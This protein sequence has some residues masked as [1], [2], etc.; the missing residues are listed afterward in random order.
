MFELKENFIDFYFDI[1][2]LNKNFDDFE[3][4]GR[5]YYPLKTNSNEIVLE[6]LLPMISRGENGFLISHLSHYYKLIKMGVKPNRMC[7]INVLA[8]GELIKMLYENGVRYFTFDNLEIL[9]RFSK[10]ADLN[11]TKIA[12]R[13][14]IT[15]VFKDKFSHLGGG[16]DECKKMLSFLKGKCEDYGISFY[17]QREIFSN[18]NS[19]N[20]MLDFIYDNFIGYNMTFLNIGGAKKPEEIDVQRIEDI[21]RQLNIDTIIIEPGRYLV[22]NCVDMETRITK[23]SNIQN[24]KTVIVKNGIY[25]GFVDILLYSKKFEIYFQTNNKDKVLLSYEKTEECDY[26]FFIC[27]GSSDSGDRFG[28][29]FINSK[30]KDEI[31]VGAKFYIKDVGAYF[32]EFFMPLGGDLIKKYNII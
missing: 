12:V 30:Y 16:A 3:K 23:I 28:S 32:E 1:N 8:E 17:L 6:Y 11:E 7:L 21:K 27:G 9:D 29:F 25:S 20:E 18:N 13:L 26:E 19:L 4:I 22:G 14:S 5:V 31:I 2:K 24:R 10:Y 15:E